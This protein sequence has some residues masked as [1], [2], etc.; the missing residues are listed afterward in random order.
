VQAPE[1][2]AGELVVVHG[3][4]LAEEAEEVLV[5][6]VEPEEAVAVHASGVAEASED[7]PGGGDCEEEEEAGCGLELAEIAPFAR[8]DEVDR[9]GTEEEDEGYEAFGEDG[10]GQGC[11]HNVGVRGG[12]K[13][14]FLR[15]GGK[16]A[17]FGRDDGPLVSR[18]I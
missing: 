17:S 15:Y 5:D 10:E 14:R 13:D 12:A 9:R 11:P 1:E 6:E 4:A 18:A 8:E 3:V 16:C 7:V 2:I